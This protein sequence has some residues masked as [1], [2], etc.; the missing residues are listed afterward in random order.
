MMIPYWVCTILRDALT[1]KTCI[2]GKGCPK[3]VEL[4]GVL[5]W[6]YCKW[7]NS[8]EFKSA[9]TSL[10]LLNPVLLF[11]LL[12]LVTAS[13]VMKYHFRH[14]FVAATVHV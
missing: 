1:N 13:S 2:T 8:V 14:T 12:Y 3:F 11:N 9:C 7:L 10:P 4:A 6:V 5:S